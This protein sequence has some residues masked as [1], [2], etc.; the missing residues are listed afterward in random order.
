MGWL[1]TACIAGYDTYLSCL[2]PPLLSSRTEN[3]TPGVRL[4]VVT[5][6]TRNVFGGI[7]RGLLDIHSNYVRLHLDNLPATRWPQEM[8][9]QVLD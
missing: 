3:A 4:R 7:L 5:P 1:G 2:H 6:V 9:A 8:Q